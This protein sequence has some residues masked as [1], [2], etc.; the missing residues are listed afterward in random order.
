MR[1]SNVTGSDG[2][3]LPEFQKSASFQ[4]FTVWTVQPVRTFTKSARQTELSS[5]SALFLKTGLDS[6]QARQELENGQN[7]RRYLSFWSF[8][9][10]TPTELSAF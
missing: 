7:E 9:E 5:I 1:C 2:L 10:I 3:F 8:R 4:L 6:A